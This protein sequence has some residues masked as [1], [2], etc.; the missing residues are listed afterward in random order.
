MRGISGGS[1]CARSAT[2]VTIAAT[3]PPNSKFERSDKF[4]IMGDER[5]IKFL[6]MEE[7]SES[8]VIDRMVV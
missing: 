3:T 7:M 1:N 6:S 4:L 8:A 5:S 2:T